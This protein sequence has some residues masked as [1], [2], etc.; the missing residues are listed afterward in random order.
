MSEFIKNNLNIKHL[1]LFVLLA[2]ASL[3]FM[4]DRNGYEGDDLNIVCGIF[5]LD[6]A[7]AGDIDIYRYSW[8]PL[9]FALGSVL[10]KITGSPTLIFLLS[11][12][13]ATCSLALMLVSMSNAANKQH[14]ILVY[15][16]ILI[17]IP[18]LWFSGLYFNTS[19]LAMPFVSSALLI[20]QT[21]R[22]Y[23]Y[24]FLAGLLLGVAI[25][26]R[27]DFVLAAPMLFVMAWNGNQTGANKSLLIGSMLTVAVLVVLGLGL[28]T[29]LVDIN[30]LVSDYKAATEEMHNMAQ[31]PG[32]NRVAKNWIF[33]I[34]IYP[35]AWILLLAG[36][37][38]FIKHD[39]RGNAVAKLS[40][41]LAALPMLYGLPNLLSVKYLLPFFVFLPLFF[42]RGY[43]YLAE[44]S[45]NLFKRNIAQ[46][47]LYLFALLALF[48]SIEPQKKPPFVQVSF[49]E[50]WQVYTHDG[51][52]TYGA[53]LA[54]MLKVDR[55]SK[56]E[57]HMQAAEELFRYMKT[58]NTANVLVVGEEN[59]F[60]PGGIGWRQFQLLAERAGIHGKV[61]GSHLMCFDFGGRYLWLGIRQ[62]D[63]LDR[64]FEQYRL[65][66]LVIDLTDGTLL[67]QRAYDRVHRAIAPHA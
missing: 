38:D 54:Q 43:E 24:A 6:A 47:G 23:R 58:E 14:G 33:T 10:F 29:N 41:I 18:E 5:Q 65:K 3:I 55:M 62:A 32:W 22:S 61:I 60:A 16:A 53:Y 28:L 12:L 63:D 50:P 26:I 34:I 52:R 36:L 2:G 4:A 40:Y 15:A 56:P 25:L 13:A 27:I 45:A 37:Y 51:Y 1:G 20:V 9:A 44:I 7:L 21:Q 48:V 17:L 57:P 11:P 66:P 42:M 8:Q 64:I 49:I 30:Q 46:T 59:Y 67:G 31:A 35:F 39:S 19:I